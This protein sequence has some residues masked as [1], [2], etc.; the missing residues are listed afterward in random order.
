[1]S[2]A[3][4]VE[5]FS[6][7][8]NIRQYSEEEKVNALAVY[9]QVGS[10]EK[11]SEVLGIPMSTLGTWA[12]NTPYSLEAR[13]IKR[14]DLAEKFENAAHLY[15]DLAV[16]KAKKAPFNHL[17]AGAGIAFDKMQISRGLPTSITESVERQELVV[18][19]QS[20]LSAGLGEVIDVE[21][22]SEK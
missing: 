16:K 5:Q 19:L 13:N 18:I 4:E 7:R 12:A 15:L 11:A 22:E 9:D 14:Q 21:A 8:R 20:A 3:V 17:M 6:S 1:M 10:L 2:A